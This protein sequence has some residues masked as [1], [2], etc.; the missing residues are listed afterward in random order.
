LGQN[1]VAEG[2]TEGIQTAM[3]LSFRP[4]LTVAQKAEQIVDAVLTG[5]A[6]GGAYGGVSGGVGYFTNPENRPSSRDVRGQKPDQV[7]DDAL[8]RAVDND[9][10]LSESSPPDDQSPPAAPLALPEPPERLALPAPSAPPTNTTQVRDYLR[11]RE[12]RSQERR[13]QSAE[14]E[15]LQN[16]PRRRLSPSNDV[17]RR[18]RA[19]TQQVIADEI[20]KKT[21]KPADPKE[22]ATRL[23]KADRKFLAGLTRDWV[24]GFMEPAL[25]E[26]ETQGNTAE[27][28]AAE[29]F[30]KNAEAVKPI[31][32]ARK[33]S[34]EIDRVEARGERM[35][36]YLERL[37]EGL[38][39]LEAPEIIGGQRYAR[40]DQQV[41]AARA[42]V[43][44]AIAERSQALRSR[45]PYNEQK[46]TD[47]RKRRSKRRRGYSSTGKTNL[48]RAVR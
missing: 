32:L 4:D 41:A 38:G 33:V 2:A 45:T 11:E 42:E 5:G 9:L 16:L 35:P 46:I 34:A 23:E 36:V 25:V 14:D 31:D 47:A 17:Y 1:T 6:V 26:L 10:G 44:K 15:L 22:V 37:A 7:Q 29:K 48:R 12:T 3:E 39:V 28:E 30:L 18:W 19:N 27:V 13:A 43:N 24:D 8:E 21:G 20:E 40:L